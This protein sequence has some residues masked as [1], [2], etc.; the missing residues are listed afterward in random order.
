[1]TSSVRLVAV[2]GEVCILVLKGMKS[3]NSETH[4]DEIWGSQALRSISSC[5]KSFFKVC[6]SP[7]LSFP[8]TW[9]NGFTEWSI[10]GRKHAHI[11]FLGLELMNWI[12]ELLPES[13]YVNTKQIWIEASTTYFLN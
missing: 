2:P 1:M 11:P 10:V 13:L 9:N 8:D 6:P 4:A 12:W 5:F 7:V 3:L